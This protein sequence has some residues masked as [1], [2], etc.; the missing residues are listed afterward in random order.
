[1]CLQVVCVV[2]VCVFVSAL[3]DNGRGLGVCPQVV[4]VVLVCAFVSALV[5]KN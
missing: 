4:C 3:V 2:L 5:Y 1:M